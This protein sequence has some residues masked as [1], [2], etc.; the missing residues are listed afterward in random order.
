MLKNFNPIICN[1]LQS[2]ASSILTD[3]FEYVILLEG[4]K[5]Q[6]VYD[7]SEVYLYLV[8]KIMIT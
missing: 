5:Q 1:L 4:R 2:D 6:L 8:D 7:I 3:V